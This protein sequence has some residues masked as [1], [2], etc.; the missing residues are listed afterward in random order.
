MPKSCAKAKRAAL[1]FRASVCL[2]P[3]P[4]CCRWCCVRGCFREA[5][6]TGKAPGAHSAPKL[7]A[8]VIGAGVSGLSAATVLAARGV[9]VTLIE[10]AGQ[11]GGRCR[12]YFDSAIGGVIDNG[13]HLVLSG[14]RAVN[15]YVKRI[16]TADALQ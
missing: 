16:G 4:N 1:P 2:C 6:M 7:K 13:N 5:R 11:A 3:S 14:N 9:S 12:S 8:F 15:A 10:A